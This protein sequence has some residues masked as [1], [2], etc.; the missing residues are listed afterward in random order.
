MQTFES[1][2]LPTDKPHGQACP[3]C[4]RKPARPSHELASKNLKSPFELFLRLHS[5][6]ADCFCKPWQLSLMG[7][8]PPHTL[9]F[10]ICL[11]LAKW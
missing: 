5:Q 11:V 2:P 3:H 8:L 4:P 10:G 1:M 9:C 6:Q 7:V